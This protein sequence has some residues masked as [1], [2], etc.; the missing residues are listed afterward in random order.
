MLFKHELKNTMGLIISALIIAGLLLIIV[1]IVFIP[2]TTVVG[3]I[4]V[5]LS[6]VG[7]FFGYRE[8]G[9]STGHVILA[10]TTA[11]MGLMVYYAF[12]SKTW[13][14][15]ALKTTID[16]RNNEGFLE[17]FKINEEGI[18]VSALR[19]VGKAEFNKRLV[20][21]SS[22]GEYVDAGTKVR[23]KEVS[24]AGIIVAQIV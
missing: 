6:F 11:A 13:N 24:A 5:V 17:S 7:V 4:G 19:P 23:I 2:G 16:S 3:V 10:T 8:Y 20:E 9:S 21:V 14:K 1:E 18:C 15:L 22:E 12:Q